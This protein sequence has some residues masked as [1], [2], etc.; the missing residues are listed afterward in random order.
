M[1]KEEK[2]KVVIGDQHMAIFCHRCLRLPMGPLQN[3][4][5]Y[6]RPIINP[7][8]ALKFQIKNVNILGQANCLGLRKLM[9]TS[10]LVV[11][12]SGSLGCWLV[13]SGKKLPESV[14][15]WWLR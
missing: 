11:W 13:G 15:I 1:A 6:P 4:E 8:P 3:P 14:D 5:W 12:A 7:H 10:N 9:S 2:L